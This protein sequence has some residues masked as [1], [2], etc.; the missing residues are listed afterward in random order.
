M[1]QDRLIGTM[2][3]LFLTPHHQQHKLA[4][5]DGIVASNFFGP[6]VQNAQVLRFDMALRLHLLW[7]HNATCM[8]FIGDLVVF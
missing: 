6:A 1:R 4:T 2:A 3:S 5:T 7:G 8:G